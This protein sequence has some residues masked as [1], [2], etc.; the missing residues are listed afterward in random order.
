MY[1]RE[2]VFLRES[3]FGSATIALKEFID[4]Y[5]LKLEAAAEEEEEIG[6]FH[7]RKKKSDK[8]VGFVDVSIRVSGSDHSQTTPFLGPEDGFVL[9]D[10][11]HP[12]IDPAGSLHPIQPHSLQ[13]SSYHH[14]FGGANHV[15]AATGS[16]YQPPPGLPPVNVGY[17]PYVGPTTPAD[18]IS[19]PSSVAPPGHGAGPRPG[20]GMG[21]AAGGALAAG[22][23]IYGEDLVSEFRAPGASYMGW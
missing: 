22:A 21:L 5:E 13:P 20:F 1:S 18:Y 6:S 4:K 10:P 15:S 12:T 3:L 19:M 16:S 9:R 11:V 8:A 14:Q 2:P 23:M 7:L 17:G